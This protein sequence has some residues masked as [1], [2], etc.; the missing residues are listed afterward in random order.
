MLGNL[1]YIFQKN[2]KIKNI[3]KKIKARKLKEITINKFKKYKNIIKKKK[4]SDLKF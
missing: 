1:F 2:I 4:L 3:K